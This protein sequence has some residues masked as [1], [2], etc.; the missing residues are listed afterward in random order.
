[1]QWAEMALIAITVGVVAVV[2]RWWF[3]D[4]DSF[5]DERD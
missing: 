1:M 5:Y 2:A 4:K 3:F